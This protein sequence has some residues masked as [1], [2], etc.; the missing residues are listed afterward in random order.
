MGW[1]DPCAADPLSID[2]LRKL[3]VFWIDESPT[4]QR[5]RSIMPGGGP[6][7]VMITRLHVRYAKKT[8]PEDLFF[9]ETQDTQNFQGRYVLRHP[10]KG[11]PNSCPQAGLYAK[12]LKSRQEQEAKN[13]AGL[14][15]WDINDIRKKSGMDKPYKAPNWWESLWQ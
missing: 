8:F 2:E 11:N 9:Q 6:L 5:S 3:G 15:G 4:M 7:P 10:W 14:T 1:C 13:L 12:S